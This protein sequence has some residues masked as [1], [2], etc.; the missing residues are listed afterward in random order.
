MIFGKRS[1]EQLVTVHKDL[2]LIH[3]TAI[4]T[5]PVDYGIHQGARSYQDQLKYF[6][7]G[8]SKLDPR[9][10]EKLQ[11]AKH[12]VGDGVRDKAEATDIHI[13]AKHQGTSL[14]W[15]EEHLTFVAGYLIAIADMLYEQG[16][17]THKLLWG[18]NWDHD[19]V[20]LLDQTFIDNPHFQLRDV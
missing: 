20:I 1:K 18:G 15:N 12:V 16:K 14:T 9:I 13:S 11:K 4:K 8:K 7:N 2:K 17:I 3:E 5:I 19:S 10:S 6:L